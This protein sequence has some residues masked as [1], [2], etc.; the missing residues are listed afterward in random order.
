MFALE[1]KL[2]P[3]IDFGILLGGHIGSH[4]GG[5]LVSSHLHMTLAILMYLVELLL[6]ENLYFATNIIKLPALEQEVMNIH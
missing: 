1:Q 6:L 2:R 4:L 5:H 3:F